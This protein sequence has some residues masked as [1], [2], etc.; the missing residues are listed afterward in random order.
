MDLPTFSKQKEFNSWVK[1]ALIQVRQAGIVNMEL[2]RVA[3]KCVINC[4]RLYVCKNINIFTDNFEEL[5][6]YNG[7]LSYNTLVLDEPYL[8]KLKNKK[9]ILK[10]VASDAKYSYMYSK[11]Y[12][13]DRFPEGELAITKDS[14]YQRLYLEFL[15][16]LNK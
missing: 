2:G 16:K 3:M 6:S 5:I 14:H 12:L 7:V 1:K 13:K 11:I 8:S 4:D 9:S 10:K 15:K